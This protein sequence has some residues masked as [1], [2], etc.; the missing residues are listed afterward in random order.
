MQ[1][2]HTL[3]FTIHADNKSFQMSNFMLYRDWM[4]GKSSK[5]DHVVPPPANVL[6][7]ERLTDA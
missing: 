5:H 1:N 7:V 6:N 4:A 3:S 2:L